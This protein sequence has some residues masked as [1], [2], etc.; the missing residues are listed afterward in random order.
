M[1]ATFLDTF[2]VSEASRRAG[3]SEKTIR[4][5]IPDWQADPEKRKLITKDT[6]SNSYRIS[7]R[8]IE[9]EF[10][11]ASVPEFNNEQLQ[12]LQTEFARAG[13]GYRQELQEKNDQLKRKD[14]QITER[15]RWLRGRQKRIEK[16]ERSL[17]KAQ[18]RHDQLA[19]GLL[20]KA[21]GLPDGDRAIA[22]AL[23]LPAPA[24]TIDAETVYDEQKPEQQHPTEQP[25]SEPK[26]WFFQFRKRQQWRESRGVAATTSVES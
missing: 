2:T 22:K 12:F 18:E 20:A 6:K 7:R 14:V 17:Q 23:G 16:L 10:P 24:G 1:T 25:L 21:M 11:Q 13:Q 19:S 26:P 8:L 4:R 5:R 9:A 3:T 15:D